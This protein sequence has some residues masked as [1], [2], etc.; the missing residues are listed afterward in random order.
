MRCIKPENINIVLMACGFDPPCPFG[1]LVINESAVARG[2][3][4]SFFP[5][6]VP[7]LYHHERCLIRFPTLKT[8][9]GQVRSSA[10]KTHLSSDGDDLAILHAVLNFS[11]VLRD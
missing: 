8:V 10:N 6:R 7:L 11:V 9:S 3:R 4:W 1:W 2:R 5:H